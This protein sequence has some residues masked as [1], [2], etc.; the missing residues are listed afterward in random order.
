MGPAHPKALVSGPG[1]L[2]RLGPPLTTKHPQRSGGQGGPSLLGSSCLT[3]ASWEAG[4]GLPYARYLPRELEAE[5]ALCL[6]MKEG[7][8]LGSRRVL[9][10]VPWEPLVHKR[11]TCPRHCQTSGCQTQCRGQT[12]TLSKSSG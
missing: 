3:L 9:P 2:G 4:P 1:K 5:S 8:G 7:H 10:S 12:E 6:S 11:P